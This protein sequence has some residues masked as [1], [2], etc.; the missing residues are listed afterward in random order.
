MKIAIYAIVGSVG[1][2]SAFLIYRKQS[3]FDVHT[4]IASAKFY[5][6][7]FN[8]CEYVSQQNSGGGDI[9]G[10][11]LIDVVQIDSFDS[12]RGSGKMNL[13]ITDSPLRG[14]IRSMY[15]EKEERGESSASQPLRF[16]SYEKA[17]IVELDE[18][19]RITARKMV[20]F[21][22]IILQ[23]KIEPNVPPN[24][25]KPVAESKET[26]ISGGAKPASIP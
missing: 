19:Q 13:F 16:A 10:V 12:L 5:K 14:L 22:F 1:I 21:G 2:L 25:R 11:K 26:E 18:N 24:Q 20:K 9:Q 4:V 3:H 23:L 15:F 7:G 8:N 17:E 6:L